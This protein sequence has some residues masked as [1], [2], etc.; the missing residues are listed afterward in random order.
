MHWSPSMR[1][2]DCFTCMACSRSYLDW[3]S[4]RSDAS[5]CRSIHYVDKKTQYI[6]DLSTWLIVYAVLIQNIEP[7]CDHYVAIIVNWLPD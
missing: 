2:V 6:N 5:A 4:R 3:R 7:S 1:N